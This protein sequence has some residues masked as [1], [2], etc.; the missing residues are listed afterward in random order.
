MTT[1][2]DLVNRAWQ[3][4]T[5]IIFGENIGEL[6]DYREYLKEGLIGKSVVSEFSGKELWVVSE[7]YC[8]AA[9]F[10]E[11]GEENKELEKIMAKPFDINKI[12]DIDSLIETV[13]ERLIYSG[14]KVLGNS[15]N[16][17]SSDAV[18]D[19]T[20]IMNSSLLIGNK[21]VAYSYLM[22]YSE[23][24]FGSAS[25]GQSAHI[26]RCFYNNSLKRC[27]ECST[28]VA[29]SDCYFSYNV[30]NC[31]DC[32]FTFNQRT[33]QHMIANVQLDNGKYAE[34]KHK[35]LGEV[36]EELKKR[37]RLDYSIIDIINGWKHD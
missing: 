19:S 15:R 35:L 7:E 23:Y 20:N 24:S 21:Y 25:S 27:F 22:Q 8:P 17:I 18:I 3:E 11:Y 29:A 34:L 26:I 16:V 30:M 1:T 28:S 36:K 12:K 10:F 2:Y 32:L 13:K 4:T 5:R 31:S 6:Q 37:K 33:R 9:R 14:N